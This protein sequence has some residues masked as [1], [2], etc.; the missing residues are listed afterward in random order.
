MR[1][2]NVTTHVLTH[3]WTVNKAFFG[4]SCPELKRT[5]ISPETL[6]TLHVNLRAYKQSL[7]YMSALDIGPV[8]QS[9]KDSGK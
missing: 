2:L 3:I 8:P 9:A 6:N 5:F 7:E 4:P 1:E